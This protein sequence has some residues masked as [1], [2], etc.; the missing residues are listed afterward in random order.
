MDLADLETTKFISQKEF[1]IFEEK[2]NQLI[3]NQKLIKVGDD[4]LRNFDCY[5]YQSFDN[6][7]IYCLSVPDNSWR[8][9][10]LNYEKAK[11]HI[12]NLKKLDKQKSTGCLFSL[13]LIILITLIGIIFKNYL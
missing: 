6:N 4:T 7:K 13:F 12:I 10:F 11:R 9:F 3:A 2:L 5:L 8:G 1:E